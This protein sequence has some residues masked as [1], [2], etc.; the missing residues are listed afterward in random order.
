MDTSMHEHTFF[1]AGPYLI[2][3]CGQAAQDF[4]GTDHEGDMVEGIRYL[5]PQELADIKLGE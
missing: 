3:Q 5:T 1:D 4:I 2:C